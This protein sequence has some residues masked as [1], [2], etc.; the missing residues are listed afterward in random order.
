MPKMNKDASKILVVFL[1]AVI[2]LANARLIQKAQNFV[3]ELSAAFAWDDFD[4]INFL[5]NGFLYD[6]IQFSVDFP[7]A[8]VNVV[9]V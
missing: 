5:V 8:I 1:D 9:Q 7:A 6:A 3:L 2:Q 4:E